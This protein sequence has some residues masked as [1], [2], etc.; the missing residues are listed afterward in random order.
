[1]YQVTDEQRQG[2]QG[3]GKEFLKT[4]GL[5]PAQALRIMG[6]EADEPDFSRAL[7]AQAMT[8]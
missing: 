3:E 1:M 7:G 4:A 2:G 6:T 8:R 5:L